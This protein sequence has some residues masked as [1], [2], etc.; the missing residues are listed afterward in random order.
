VTLFAAEAENSKKRM[1]RE[2]EKLV[3]YAGENILRGL[4]NTADNLE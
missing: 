1:E 4:L 3:K 2:R